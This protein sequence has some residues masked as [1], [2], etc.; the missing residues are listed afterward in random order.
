MF[1]ENEGFG[2]EAKVSEVD[3]LVFADDALLVE[4]L[5]RKDSRAIRLQKTK[6]KKL[7]LEKLYN[8]SSVI[9][10]AHRASYDRDDAIGVVPVFHGKDDPVAFIKKGKKNVTK[11]TLNKVA[12]RKLRYQKVVAPEP[13]LEEDDTFNL[14]EE[15]DWQYQTLPIGENIGNKVW[16]AWYD[17]VFFVTMEAAGEFK[18][19]EKSLL[20]LSNLNDTLQSNKLEESIVNLWKCLERSLL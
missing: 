16:D 11:Q 18:K 7:R 17:H 14:I 12:N 5:S 13:I 1:L 6:N 4:D 9:R 3:A 10:Y 15:H 19:I 8:P 20:R 2:I